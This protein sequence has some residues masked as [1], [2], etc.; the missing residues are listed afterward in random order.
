MKL[1]EKEFNAILKKMQATSDNVISC[2]NENKKSYHQ[3]YLHGIIF[4]IEAM[5]YRT[6]T[7]TDMQIHMTK[8]PS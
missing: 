8:F 3:G 6:W 4:A 5:G 1:T 7:D 2:M